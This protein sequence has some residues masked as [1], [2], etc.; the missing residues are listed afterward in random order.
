MCAALSSFAAAYLYLP[1]LALA[2]GD[3]PGRLVPECKGFDGAE[4]ACGFNDFVM[5]GQN[6]LK[7]AIY[8]AALGAIVAIIYAG[9]LYLSS[10]GNS[11]KISKAHGIFGKAIA[12]IIITM[13]AWLIVK[14]IL[15]GLGVGDQWTLL[16]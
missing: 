14:S 7:W 1:A 5:L 8:L 15:T 2:A 16:N 4:N 6:F 11:S 10:A 12:G 3:E 13:A 9:W